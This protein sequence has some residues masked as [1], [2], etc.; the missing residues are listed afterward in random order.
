VARGDHAARTGLV[1]REEPRLSVALR[2]VDPPRSEAS[3]DS[4]WVDPPRM[5]S[6]Q[7][8]MGRPTAI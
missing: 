5:R 4:R 8:S 1:A 2:W 7:I 3:P 6:A